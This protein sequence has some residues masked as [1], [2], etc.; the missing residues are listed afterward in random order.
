MKNKGYMLY[1]LI[2][3]FV[4]TTVISIFLLSAAFKLNDKNE[5]L[6]VS[7]KMNVIQEEVT[8]RF[9]QDIEKSVSSYLIGSSS[10]NGNS[11]CN[12]LIDGE[13]V[14]IGIDSNKNTIYYRDYETELPEG[15]NV[16]NINCLSTYD[17][18]GYDNSIF[19]AIKEGDKN[20]ALA[21]G[22]AIED[23]FSDKNY[24]INIMYLYQDLGNLQYKQ[25]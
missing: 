1:E 3:A 4:L 13:E 9:Y 2:V 11:Y 5:E 21:I 14:R 8:A 15:I 19:H 23:N 22:I 16:K 20:S 6:T 24:D 7:S 17:G 10:V 12:F 25:G 18:L